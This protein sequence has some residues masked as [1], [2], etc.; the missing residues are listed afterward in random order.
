VLEEEQGA[1]AHVFTP[2]DQPVYVGTRNNQTLYFRGAIDEL[3]VADV[4]FTAEQVGRHMEGS[5]VF[6][7]PAGSLVTVWGK[8]KK[9]SQ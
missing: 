1:R 2:D 4:P 5:L 6:V 7:R 9:T 3:L 8:L